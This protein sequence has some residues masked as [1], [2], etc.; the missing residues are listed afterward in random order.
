MNAISGYGGFDPQ[1][2]MQKMQEKLSTAD[3]DGSGGVSKAELTELAQADG[4]PTHIM[5]KMF[6]KADANGDGELSEQEQQEMFTKMEQRMAQMQSGGFG[7][8]GAYTDAQ[9]SSFKS[10]LESLQSNSDDDK[11][12]DDLQ[13]A[14]DKLQQQGG[15]AGQASS[16][17]QFNQIAP[18]IDVFA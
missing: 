12:K 10:L 3:V 5:D 4:K 1:Q 13:S 6:S 9:D 8:I 16:I 18:P 17:Q 2:M 11:E 14:I 15:Y 7:A